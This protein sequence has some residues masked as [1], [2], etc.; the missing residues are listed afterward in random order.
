MRGPL[1]I[2]IF[3]FDLHIYIDFINKTSIDA[4]ANWNCKTEEL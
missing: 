4:I 3:Y 2:K 1:N